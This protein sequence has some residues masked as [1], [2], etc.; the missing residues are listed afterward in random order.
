MTVEKGS[1]TKGELEDFKEEMVHQFHIFYEKMT[2]LLKQIA[3]G[4]ASV[5]DKL[6]RF[7]HELKGDIGDRFGILSHR[8]EGDH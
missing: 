1:R 7:H 5:N 6:D 3:E 8:A 2:S 4:V